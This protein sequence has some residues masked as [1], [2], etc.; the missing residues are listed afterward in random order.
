MNEIIT[1]INKISELYEKEI[2]ISKERTKIEEEITKYLEKIKIYSLHCIENKLNKTLF[3]CAKNKIIIKLDNSYYYDTLVLTKNEFATC[4]N[5]DLR[6]K[7][8]LRGISLINEINDD[9]IIIECYNK[10]KIPIKEFTENKNI[11]KEHFL[12]FIE[13]FKEYKNSNIEKEIN[14]LE[15]GIIFK[16]FKLKLVENYCDDF[17]TISL[18]KLYYNNP[19]YNDEGNNKIIEFI[20]KMETLS[21]LTTKFV[22]KINDVNITFD[23]IEKMKNNYK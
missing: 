2:E 16:E 9:K 5:G 14:E 13:L 17:C 6:T 11:N 18:H 3:N 4:T 8:Y 7:S 15:G 21:D 12:K 1:K 20:N 10:H 19:N 22:K 23:I